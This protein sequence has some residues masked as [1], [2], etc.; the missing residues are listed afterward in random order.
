MNI[1]PALTEESCNACDGRGF[2]ET[3][4]EL[5]ECLFCRGLGVV[6]VATAN[7]EKLRNRYP[8]GFVEGGGVR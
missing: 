1:P 3:R 4:K 6:S 8:D 7:V 2:R 5:A